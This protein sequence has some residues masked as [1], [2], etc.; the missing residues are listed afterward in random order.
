MTGELEYRAVVAVA[1][2]LERGEVESVAADLERGEVESVAVR[3]ATVDDEMVDVSLSLDG[4]DEQPDGAFGRAPQIVDAGVPFELSGWWAP[5]P[6]QRWAR[7][8]DGAA[9]DV[10][11]DDEREDAPVRLQRPPARSSARS[12]PYALAYKDV[13]PES[14]PGGT[15]AGGDRLS[16]RVLPGASPARVRR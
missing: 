2:D 10:G 7:A 15:Q 6:D 8:I 12:R 16:R 11:R 9:G 3:A 13:L 5:S 4:E 1:A 14:H